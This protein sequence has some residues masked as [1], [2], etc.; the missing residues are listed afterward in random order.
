MVWLPG[1]THVE[2]NR[3][4]G[5]GA[6][7]VLTQTLAETSFTETRQQKNRETVISASPFG[8]LSSFD[9]PQSLVANSDTYRPRNKKQLVLVAFCG[10]PQ[11][12][13][14]ASDCSQT[15]TVMY[16]RAS[17]TRCKRKREIC[18]FR[19]LG[20]SGEKWELGIYVYLYFRNEYPAGPLRCKR[21]CRYR[22]I[23]ARSFGEG[24]R[25]GR[26]PLEL[27]PSRDALR[28]RGA[29][30]L[31]SGMA[32]CWQGARI[33]IVY[34]IVITDGHSALFFLGLRGFC[35]DGSPRYCCGRGV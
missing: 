14:H 16:R 2:M 30:Q 25:A 24:G 32:G 20:K 7:S 5:G 3:H 10:W 26:V 34:C 9:F 6:P 27:C 15:I 23:R 13:H 11:H 35:C 17:K 19:S 29:P 31:A 12:P 18:F 33:G 8:S 22:G 21:K 1:V 28:E 4:G